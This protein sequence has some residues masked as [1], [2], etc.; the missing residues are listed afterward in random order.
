MTDFHFSKTDT[1]SMIHYHGSKEQRHVD[2]LNQRLKGI[3][4]ADSAAIMG[5]SPWQTAYDLWEVKT[6]ITT[7]DDISGKWSVQ[8]GHALEGAL[9]DRFYLLHVGEGWNVYDGTLKTFVSRKHPFMLADLDGV[10]TKPGEKTPGVLE[11]KT[12]SRRSDWD[13]GEGGYQIPLYYLTQVTHYLAVTGWTWG[14]VYVAFPVG[15]PVEIPFKRDEDD[16]AT[17]IGAESTFWDHVEKKTAPALIG[18]NDV[19]EA[20]PS[21]NARTETLTG[22]QADNLNTLAQKLDQTE[23]QI[24]KYESDK[25][26]LTD[27]LSVLIGKNKTV[28]TDA[29]RA[30]LNT[31]HYKAQPARTIPAKPART[32]RGRVIVK[33]LKK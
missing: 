9:R 31:I 20:F 32:L 10:I 28:Q 23:Q 19:R 16:I 15:D 25:K 30:S 2:W 17:L 29:W 24:R 26:L 11:I 4:G 1:Y 7:G 21:D 13:D 12:A 27:E 5:V 18:L 33:A 14:Y 8:K 22:A 3:G 6:R